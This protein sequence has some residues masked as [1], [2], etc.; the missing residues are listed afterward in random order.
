MFRMPVKTSCPPAENFNEIA[1]F[2]YSPIKEILDFNVV[3]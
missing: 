3:S 2:N 1:L